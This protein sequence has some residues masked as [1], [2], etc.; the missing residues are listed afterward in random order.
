MNNKISDKIIIYSVYSLIF[1]S[2]YFFR[3]FYFDIKGILIIFVLAILPTLSF[4]KDD[5]YVWNDY[6]NRTQKR[7]KL[8]KKLFGKLD[9]RKEE[10]YN[11][12]NKYIFLI[13]RFVINLFYWS[14]VFCAL[15]SI[16]LIF[17]EIYMLF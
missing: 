12:K 8:E 5:L 10:G 11:E 4:T 6:H 7:V 9:W 15:L 13:K 14:I 1:I 3:S 17:I 16:L 2:I